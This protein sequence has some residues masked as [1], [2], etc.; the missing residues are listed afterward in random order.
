MA[1]EISKGHL[2][3]VVNSLTW[4]HK[5]QLHFWRFMDGVPPMHLNDRFWKLLEHFR[6]LVKSNI[7]SKK[8]EPIKSAAAEFFRQALVTIPP[9]EENEYLMEEALQWLRG[10]RA[11]TRQLDGA[12]ADLFDFHGDSF[13]D[14]IDSMPLGGRVFCERALK[15][16]SRSRDGFLS[17]EELND[18]VKTIDQPWRD[19]IGHE[20]YVV[21][22]LD[23]MA[24]NYLISWLRHNVMTHEHGEQ[25]ES[26]KLD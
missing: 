18:A 26:C 6:K 9:L 21:S 7:N 13:G 16:H 15:T 24:E 17:E 1:L 12:L 3:A 8:A 23:E 5:A 25:I 11:L 20:I 22:R 10:Y 14:L 2:E 19:L 4:H